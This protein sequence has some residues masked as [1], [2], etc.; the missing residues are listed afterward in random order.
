MRAFLVEALHA[1]TDLDGRFLRSFRTLLMKPGELTVAYRA[2]RRKEFLGPLQA[3]LVANVAFFAIEALSRDHVF[4]TSLAS[5]V[6][7]QDWKALAQSIVNERLQR[8]D[9]SFDDYALRFDLAAARNAKMLVVLMTLPF[10]LLLPLFQPGKARGI[11][12]RAAFSLHLYAFLLLLFSA[13]LV[14][15]DLQLALGGDGLHSPRVD[16]WLSALLLVGCIAYL[17]LAL[18]RVYPAGWPARL[19]RSFGL[20]VVVAAIVPGYRFLIFIITLYTTR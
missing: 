10:M 6:G 17:F 9:T 20:G 5:H 12:V 2:G 7:L 18:G 3:F 1:L 4:A 11:V 14:F 13:A 15:A 8:L 19:L 16:L